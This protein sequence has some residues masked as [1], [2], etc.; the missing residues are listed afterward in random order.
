MPRNDAVGFFWDDTPPPKPPKAEKPKRVPPKPTWLLEDYLPG[1][2]EARRFPVHVMT[3]DELIRAASAGEELVVDAEIFA[4]YILFVFTSV[5][6]G[7]VFYLEE[8]TGGPPMDR[9]MLGWILSTF[10]TIGFN[11]LGFDMTMAYMAVAGLGPTEL[12]AAANMYILE[13]IRSYQ[14][15]KKYKTKTFKVNHIDLIE[16]APLFGSLKTY[17]A[18]LH[19]PKIQDLPFHPETVLSEAQRAIVRWY[20]VN[21]TILTAYLYIE[22]KEHIELRI[23]FGQQYG[24]DFRSLSDA[25]MAE[26]VIRAEVKRVTG[27]NP[28]KPEFGRSVGLQFYYKPPPYIHFH[29]PELQNA[30]HQMSSSLITVGDN[31]HAE[32]PKSLRE[33][34]VVIGG[35]PYKVG[36]G[37]LHSKEEAQALVA[38]HSLRIFD[39]D[40]T[41]YYPNLILKN[42]FGPVDLGRA[43]LIAFQRMVDRRTAAKRE[44][45]RLDGL[46]WNK[47]DPHYKNVYAEAHGLKIANNGIFGK[48]MDP[49]SIVY[50]VPNGVQTTLTGQLSLL[51]A[52]EWLELS[53]IPVVSANTDGIVIAAPPNRVGDMKALFIGWEKHTGLETEETEY[54]AIYSANVNN[55]IAIKPDGKTKTKGWYCERGSAHNSVL[56]KNPEALICSDAVQAYLSKG[57][58]IE[59]TIRNSKDIRRFVSV[60]QVTG[61]GVKVWSDEHTEYLGKTVRWY[62]AQGV[63]GEIVRAKNGHTVSRTVGAKPAMQLPDGIPDDI[64]YDWYINKSL[65]ILEDIG[66]VQH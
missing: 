53:N 45:E 10:L 39:R 62:Y 57:V 63:T 60:R 1:L 23:Q 6:T 21:D 4:N 37:G 41:G 12:K 16:I 64:D 31:G 15:L 47:E 29:T 9:N 40:V 17:G 55:Y 22:L 61:G 35:K 25:Q 19:A 46:K 11:S 48:L 38:G 59:Q 36:M 56:S 13:E 50:D 33:L 24:A 58:P 18:R 52:I 51:M 2:E 44:L 28:P 20:C 27:Q 65:S 32:C 49:F 7:H 54:K 14:I 5:K 30:L 42:G 26:A 8:W 3:Q 66:A 43:F 34:T